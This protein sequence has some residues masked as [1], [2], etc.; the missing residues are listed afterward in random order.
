M[1]WM[2]KVWPIPCIVCGDTGNPYDFCDA[3]RY[4]LPYN[5]AFCLR[6]AEPLATSYSLCRLCLTEPP[7]YD[8]ARIPLR[9]DM[10]V[11]SLILMMKNGDLPLCGLLSRLFLSSTELPKNL[12]QVLIPVP[13]DRRRQ[14]QRGFNQSLEL[15]RHIGRALKIPVDPGACLK[16]V[17]TLPQ[18][19]LNASQRRK[20]LRKAFR[21]NPSAPHYQHLAIVDDVVTTGATSGELATL[22]RDR[23]AERIEIWAIA[24]S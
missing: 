5:T 4:A 12:P 16:S 23:G 8:K 19:G 15:S 24:R 22:F 1:S 18:Q 10:P 13:M 14:Q 17:T 9:Y 7:A 2:K 11:N 20:N 6:C 21:L 3:C